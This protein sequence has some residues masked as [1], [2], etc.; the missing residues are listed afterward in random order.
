MTVHP[1]TPGRLLNIDNPVFAAKFDRAPFMIRHALCGHPLFQIPRLLELSR[2]LPEASV[3]YNAGE[4]SIGCDPAEVPRNGLSPE[5]TIRRIEE[6]RSWMVLKNVEQD[7]KYC[8]LLDVCLAEVARLSEPIRPGMCHPEAFIFLSSPRSI[9]PYHMDPEHNFL[10]Q[11]I[12]DKS[13]VVFERSLV[14]DTDAEGFYSGAHRN[15]KFQNDYMARAQTF[16][17]A[18]GQGIHVPNTM[19]HFVRNGSRVSI[20][21]SITFR[22]PDL[23]RKGEVYAFNGFMRSRGR[24]PRSFGSDPLRDS[25]KS[26]AWRAMVKYR[27]L[28]KKTAQKS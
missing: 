4:L 28:F 21:F 14:A 3:E 5:E 23:Y 10:L 24:V 25:L 6:C 15:L 7:E 20:S 2:S 13:M 22:T 27:R 17:L 19:P 9:T 1:K 8:E 18:P 11:I 16:Q 26:I 12:G